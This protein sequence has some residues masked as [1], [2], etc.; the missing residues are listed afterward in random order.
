MWG[1][2]GVGLAVYRPPDFGSSPIMGP[3]VSDF[4]TR[5]LHGIDVVRC[6]RVPGSGTGG[7]GFALR[8]EGDAGVLAK[9]R[10]ARTNELQNRSCS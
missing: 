2:N 6:V 8:H 3:C 10:F 5:L 9:L 4:G 7:L 1:F